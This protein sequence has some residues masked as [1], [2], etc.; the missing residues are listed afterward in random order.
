MFDRL[1]TI[2]R[3]KLKVYIQNVNS[4]LP[5]ETQKSTKST[6]IPLKIKQL[7]I[8]IRLF[9]FPLLF[10]QSSSSTS[11]HRKHRKNPDGAVRRKHSPISVS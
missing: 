9:S 7:L 11:K 8:F 2:K 3:K 5:I 6:K 4:V 1:K 10:L